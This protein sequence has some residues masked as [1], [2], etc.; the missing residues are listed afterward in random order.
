MTVE[1]LNLPKN[2]SL[3]DFVKRN[4]IRQNSLKMLRSGL[5]SIVMPSHRTIKSIT[6][7]L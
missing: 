5:N 4:E 7:E 3:D 6:S 2:E 1:E